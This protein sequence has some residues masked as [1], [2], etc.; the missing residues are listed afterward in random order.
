MFHCGYGQEVEAYVTY[1]LMDDPTIDV[2]VLLDDYFSHI[3]GPAGKP[4]KQLYLGIE[5]TYT[6]PANYKSIRHPGGQNAQIAWGLLGTAER[7]D[8]FGKF[9]E[10]AKALAVTEQERQNV[11]LFDLGVWKYMIEGRVQYMERMSAPI[12]TVRV[13]LVPDA[14]GDPAKVVWNKSAVLTG[15]WFERGSN[16]P[17]PRNYSGRLAYD[18]KYLYMEL[19]DP[20]DTKKLVTSPVVFPYDDWEI[21]VAAQRGLPY[22]Q[23]AVGPTGMVSVLLNGEVNWRMYVPY[24]EHG[25]KAVFD[26][27]APDKWVTRLTFPLK[28]MVLGGVKAGGTIYLNIIRVSSLAVG[29]KSPLSIDTWVPYTTVHEVDRLAEVTL[30]K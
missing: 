18:G 1:R 16:N 13:P 27:T 5:K 17:A 22:R 7:M 12:P 19:V 15:G 21:F 11:E 29:G 25:V 9:M 4:M 26:T 28:N 20:C 8:K 23:F 30:D 2:D 24:P 10:E 14:N 6:D 3:Y